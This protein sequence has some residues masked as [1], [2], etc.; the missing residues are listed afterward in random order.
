MIDAAGAPKWVSPFQRPKALASSRERLRIENG[1]LEDHCPE[2]GY[3]IVTCL[4]VIDRLSDPAEAI[5]NIE[6]YMNDSGL[7][8]LSAPFDFHEASTPDTTKHIYDLNALFSDRLAWGHVGET[9]LYYEYRS[10]R[11]SWTRLVTQV[12]AKRW[13][14]SGSEGK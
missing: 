10:H 4:N 5:D 14:V 3:D 9:E 7:L 8:I 6:R 1:T 13:N 12:V 11:R 2:Q